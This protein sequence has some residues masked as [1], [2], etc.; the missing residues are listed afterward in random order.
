MAISAFAS[1]F[2][3][4]I[5]L[6]SPLLPIRTKIIRVD[7]NPSCPYSAGRSL[8]PLQ[9]PFLMITLSHRSLKKILSKVISSVRLYQDEGTFLAKVSKN[10]FGLHPFPFVTSLHHCKNYFL[11]I[12]LSNLFQKTLHYSL[13]PSAFQK[14]IPRKGQDA[15]KYM[16]L[17]CLTFPR[18]RSRHRLL[19]Q[20]QILLLVPE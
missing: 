10:P 17:T 12:T 14:E 18:Q 20:E 4:G 15:P 7:K 1:P 3:S 11:M 5:L 6:P 19:A 16:G 8:E 9:N 2:P 13:I